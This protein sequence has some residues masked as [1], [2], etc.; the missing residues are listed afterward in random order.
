[1]LP[2]TLIAVAIALATLAIYI[3]ALIICRVLSLFI[4][5]RRHGRLVVNALL[6]ATARF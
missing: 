3:A 4:I 6:P 5:A 2:A 1:L